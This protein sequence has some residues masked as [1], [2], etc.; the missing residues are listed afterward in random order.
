MASRSGAMVL[1]SDDDCA[2]EYGCEEVDG[3]TLCVPTSGSCSCNSET[4]GTN[5]SCAKTNASGEC[6]GAETCDP[7][8]GWSAC[9]AA[10]PAEE[11]CDG[12]DNDCNGIVDDGLVEGGLCF[13]EVDG[14]GSCTGQ[15]LCIGG[16]TCQGQLPETESCNFKDDDC[17]DA[18]DEDFKLDGAWLQDAHCGTCGNDC[19]Q[20]IDNG[21]GAWS[22][23]PA[24][25]VAWSPSAMKGT[26]RSMT[27]GAL[28][29][30]VLPGM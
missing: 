13:N 9:D 7:L 4:A 17:D 20:K 26:L 11:T 3:E 18:V 19:A 14:I 28:P 8:Q 30:D 21:V 15:Q 22:G 6:Y 2:D 16:W 23:S 5:R 12:A 25:P 10:V 27:L 24:S 1:E 29:P